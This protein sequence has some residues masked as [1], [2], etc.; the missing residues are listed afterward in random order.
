MSTTTFY[1]TIPPLLVTREHGSW[2]V[3]IVPML[4][5]FAVV[6]RW[7][8]D[9]VWIVV[10]GLALF[11]GYVPAQILL[12]HLSGMPQRAEKVDQAKFWGIVYGSAGL[13]CGGILLMKGYLFLLPIGGAGVFSFLVNFYLTKKY[14]KSIGTDLIA[15]AG[16]TLS[17]PSTYYVLAGNMD[18]KG[19]ALYILN[20]LFFS[21]TV[22]YVHMKI[23]AA[24]VRK[25][26]MGWREKFSIGGVNL[27]YNGVVLALVAVFSSMKLIPAIAVLAF[28]PMLFQGMYGTI[29]LSGNVRFKFLGLILLA[30]SVI[31]GS[32]LSRT[33]R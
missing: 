5:S 4:V 6:G 19:L 32:I 20:F 21:C 18:M 23:K 30:Q 9:F 22:F 31:F 3:L 27:I 26:E 28:I 14:L 11:L 33:M 2:A 12:R 25:R 29:T 10:T 17:G 1:S 24:A 13:V 8:V 16:L 7:S 15:M